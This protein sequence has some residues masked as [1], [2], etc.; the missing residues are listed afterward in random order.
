MLATEE[1]HP[2]FDMHCYGANVLKELA[3]RQ[4]KGSSVSLFSSLVGGKESYEICRL[5]AATLQLANDHNVNVIIS[6]SKDEPLQSMALQ[7]LST[8]MAHEA[9]SEYRAPSLQQVT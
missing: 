3:A 8:R 7:L 4:C 1:A 6:C 5:F 2:T 9:M